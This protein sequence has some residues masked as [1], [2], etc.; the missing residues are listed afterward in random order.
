MIIGDYK[1]INRSLKRK[2]KDARK[3]DL[4]EMII[5]S[6]D[7]LSNVSNVFDELVF[8]REHPVPKLVKA[9]EE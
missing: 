8:A 4:T 5:V 9:D 3:K 6:V 1:G 7:Y 2:V